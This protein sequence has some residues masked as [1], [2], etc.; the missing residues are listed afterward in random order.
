[1]LTN[2]IIVLIYEVTR[3]ENNERFLSFFLKEF[4]YKKMGDSS[5]LIMHF[6]IYPT[7]VKKVSLRKISA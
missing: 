6:A 1:M 5:H 2:C 7:F 4:F 3:K